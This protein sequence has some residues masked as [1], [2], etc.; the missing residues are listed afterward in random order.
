[1]DVIIDKPAKFLRHFASM[2]TS[3]RSLAIIALV[4]IG[5]ALLPDAPAVVPPPDGGYPGGNTAEGTSALATLTTGVWNTALGCQTLL[6]LTTGNQNTATGFQALLNTTTGNMNVADGVQALFHNT[7][8]SFE[9]A[10]GFRS[11]YSNTTGTGNT[12]NGFET[13]NS[14]TSGFENTATGY[15][16]LYQNTNGGSNTA[17]G[18]QA[19]F[20][21][22]TGDANAADGWQALFK[23]TTGFGNTA[24]GTNALRSNTTGS[25]NTAMGGGALFTHIIGDN[26]T[27]IGVNALNQTTT[28]S[29]NVAVGFNA[30]SGM[31]G[32]NNMALGFDA[33]SGLTTGRN[34]IDIG[35]VG[36]Q[37]ESNTIRLGRFG[38]HTSTFIV[39]I[40]GSTVPGGVSVIVDNFGHLGTIN[41]SARFKEAIRPID[42]ASE[43][44]FALKPVAFR[45]KHE[46]DPDGIA[47]FGLVAEEVEKV[48]P[49]LVARD[50]KGD[51]YTVRYEAVNAMLLNEFL[52]EHRTVQEQK[53]TIAQ[54]KQ[55]FESK[56]AEQQKQIHALTAG[57]QKVSGQLERSKAMPNVVVNNP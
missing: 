1:L 8:G 36:M 15:R 39:G 38:T 20:S 34:N 52:K 28:G 44:I 40:S 7:T 18:V 25:G 37:G 51:V 6:R 9:T 29:N 48:N 5:L 41:S 10:T 17:N 50:A 54:L 49:D 42:K 12:G 11:L 43:A 45:Y 47:Q 26:N 27:A 30:G 2:K 24:M 19:L 55:D 3:I 23:N 13:L 57:L 33:G 53:A 35:A 46:L 32:S 56:L 22:T 21:N 16:A 31:S 4:I 14:N